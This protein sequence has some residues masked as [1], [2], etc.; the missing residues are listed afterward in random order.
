MLRKGKVRSL[1]QRQRGQTLVELALFVFWM[2]GFVVILYFLNTVFDVSQK[3]TMLL[4]TQ[5][6]VELGNHADFGMA[7]HGKDDL[8]DSKST[9]VFQLGKKTQAFL[10]EPKRRPDL[11]AKDLEAFKK[12]IDGEMKIDVNRASGDERYWNLYRFPKRRTEVSWAEGGNDFH[13]FSVQLEQKLAIVSGRNINLSSFGQ[14]DVSK[15]GLYTGSIHFNDFTKLLALSRDLSGGGGLIDDLEEL[16]QAART[17]VKND[18]S[19]SKEAEDLEK[20]LNEADGLRGG[21]TQALIASAIQVAMS[22]AM[23]AIEKGVG[24]LGKAAGGA[25]QGAGSGGPLASLANPITNIQNAASGTALSAPINALTAP[26]KNV[27]QGL[28]S[29]THG[30]AQTTGGSISGLIGQNGALMGLSQMGQGVSQGASFAGTSY[31]ELDMASIALSVPGNIEGGITKIGPALD[32]VN[33]KGVGD[34]LGAVSQMV[35]P[36]TTL[37][38]MIAPQA[39]MPLSYINTGLGV[40]QTLSSAYDGISKIGSGGLSGKSA[41][42]VLQTVGGV[43]MA[44]GGLYS[45]AAQLAG[46]D[47]APGAYIA[48]AGGA[49]VTTGAMAEFAQNLKDKGIKNP[50][51]WGKELVKENVDNFKKSVN[52]FGKTMSDAGQGISKNMAE[53]FKPGRKIEDENAKGLMGLAAGMDKTTSGKLDYV[54]NGMSPDKLTQ[55]NL[56]TAGERLKNMQDAVILNMKFHGANPNEIQAAQAEFKQVQEAIDHLSKFKKDEGVTLNTHLLAG[57]KSAAERLNE[58]LSQFIEQDPSKKQGDLLG[59]VDINQYANRQ[60]KAIRAGNTQKNLEQLA[61]SEGRTFKEL[62]A[63][64]N[65]LSNQGGWKEFAFD[66]KTVTGGNR[67]LKAEIKQIQNTKDLM[68]LAGAYYKI[69]DRKNQIKATMQA[70]SASESL[71]MYGPIATENATTARIRAGQ[72][73]RIMQNELDFNP[74]DYSP[75]V[76]ARMNAEIQK[77]ESIA[78][79]DREIISYREWLVETRKRVEEA[80]RTVID[81]TKKAGELLASTRE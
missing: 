68:T 44:I 53:I 27:A 61:V 23:S 14:V 65:D 45:T 51:D 46:K 37:T 79:G 36:I 1:N 5:A 26:L 2:T 16:R 9:V 11:D 7:E 30:L 52:D 35:V 32:N 10:Y 70:L 63:M 67:T 42:E 58:R 20:S 62:Q 78:G 72:M 73:A 28:N 8:K 66:L 76:Q 55:A 54:L 39:A 59:Q 34:V 38:S 19:L 6:F 74:N 75:T 57:A 60:I 13:P 40:A 17:L 69:Q 21:G 77:L 12:A 3:Q 31:R 18:N 48:M 29:F 22:F 4:R 71:S 56:E 43:T 24:A 47:G 80:N 25:A 49:L 33:T 64:E 41:A 81:Q 15:T 50:L